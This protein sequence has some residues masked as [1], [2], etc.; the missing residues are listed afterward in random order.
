MSSYL[1]GGVESWQSAAFS[2]SFLGTALK[3]FSW[4]SA[5]FINTDLIEIERQRFC[6]LWPER[7]KVTGCEIS[8][9]IPRTRYSIIGYKVRNARYG[10]ETLLYT[11]QCTLNMV[12][13][14]H[15]CTASC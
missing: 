2:S 12:L 7:V 8:C 9:K 10:C 4:S 6:Q 3:A 5:K 14:Q 13:L 1:K 11:V 15:D